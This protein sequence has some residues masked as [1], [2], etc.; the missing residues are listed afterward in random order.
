MW[1][2]ATVCKKVNI[3]TY[4]HTERLREYVQHSY[5]HWTDPQTERGKQSLNE[6]E[7]L[8]SHL[9][10]SV[11]ST[12]FH[13]EK[14]RITPGAQSALQSNSNFMNKIEAAI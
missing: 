6:K 11:Y 4:Y 10:K 13:P 8:C 12:H 2:I 14:F 9:Q 5:T 1:V 3:F 7:F